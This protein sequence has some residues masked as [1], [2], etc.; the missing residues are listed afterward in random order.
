[1]RKVYWIL[2]LLL[3]FPIRA[4]A[5]HEVIDARCTTELK[6]SL[7]EDAKNVAYRL[8]KVENKDD[9]TYSLLFYNVT[10]D[11]Y[12]EDGNGNKYG[13]KLENLKPG[14][15]LMISIYASNKNY[16][17]GYK[18]GSKL[19]KVPY[20]NKYSK[21]DLCKGYENY[22]LCKEDSNITMTQKEF[23]KAMS[24]Y[25]N[26]LK[27]KQ[28]EQK[29]QEEQT[30]KFDFIEFINDYWVYILIPL[31]VILITIGVVMLINKRK[32]RGIL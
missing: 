13:T 12:L 4:S 31:V 17:N 23:E 6:K 26:S 20:Y 3:L 18:A 16:C 15:S 2:L 7:R 19:I 29:Q 28:E 1:M 21:S 9:V 8:T 32:N 30:N 11:I 25:I 24:D 5:I 10:N 22:S 27:P 14:T